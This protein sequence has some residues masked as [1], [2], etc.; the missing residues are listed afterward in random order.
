MTNGTGK[1]KETIRENIFRKYGRYQVHPKKAEKM[2]KDDPSK[3]F[4]EIGAGVLADIDKKKK[5]NRDQGN[6][7]A[8][9]RRQLRQAAGSGEFDNLTPEVVDD[10]TD[11]EIMD[12]GPDW[13]G[14][15][16]KT[17]R[18]APRGKSKNAR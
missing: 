6:S 12:I 14:T 13:F 2:P 18:V 4:D 9:Y 16:R 1:Q 15:D 7:V 8:F 11:A 3:T 10:M 5:N 17:R